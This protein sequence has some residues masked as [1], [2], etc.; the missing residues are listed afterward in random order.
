MKLTVT[1]PDLPNAACR[2]DPLFDRR[3]EMQQLAICRSCAEIFACYHHAR[4]NREV[5]TWGGHVFPERGQTG[6][7]RLL[8]KGAA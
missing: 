5:G 8:G 3:D 2:N 4:K 7:I 6:P 1:V